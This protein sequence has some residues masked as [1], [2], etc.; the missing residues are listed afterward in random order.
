MS[1]LRSGGS[2]FARKVTSL[3]G[4]LLPRPDPSLERRLRDAF[5][6]FDRDLGASSLPGRD[7]PFRYPVRASEQPGAQRGHRDRNGG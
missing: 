3:T 5:D 6:R 1:P 2:S 4:Y 7:R